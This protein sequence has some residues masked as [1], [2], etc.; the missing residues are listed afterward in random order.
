[1][2]LR[3]FFHRRA[4]ALVVNPA[5]LTLAFALVNIEQQ[6]SK[7]SPLKRHLAIDEGVP[8][9]ARCATVVYLILRHDAGR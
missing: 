8:C 4:P 9:L 7:R 2:C 6:F 1:M 3:P 5:R